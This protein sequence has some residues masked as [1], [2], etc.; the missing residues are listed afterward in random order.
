MRPF[1]MGGPIECGV[2][3]DS[4]TSRSWLG[5]EVGRAAATNFTFCATLVPITR[6]LAD[7][8]PG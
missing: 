3:S 7:L 4:P 5:G 1:A 2:G 6:R 8:A